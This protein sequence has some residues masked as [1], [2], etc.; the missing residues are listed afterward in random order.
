MPYKISTFAILSIA[1][2]LLKFI[3]AESA[4]CRE[5]R[6]NLLIHE[7]SPYLLKHAQNPVNWHPWGETAFALAEKEDK[8]VFLSIG[9][10][11][12]HWCNVME[13]ESFSDP[14]VAA[15]INEVFI[16]I[17]VDREERP[18]I[19][20]IYMKACQLLSPSC[21]WPLTLFLSSEGKPFYAATYIPKEN[22]F[23]R[24][25]LLELI[26]R[27]RELW[28]QERAALL[29]SAESL[30][31]AVI[32]MTLHLPGK[33]MDSSLLDKAF[34]DLSQDFDHR[35]GGFGKGAK[36]PK[37][38]SL[39]FLLRYWHRTGNGTALDM[40]EKTLTALY[41][42]GIYDQL[43]HG[44]HRYTTDRKWRIP[45]FEKM[46]YDQ[47]LLAMVYL[48][49]YQATGKEKYARIARKVLTYV[50]AHL[51]SKNGGFYSAESGDSEGEEGRFYLWPSAEIKNILSSDEW[52]AVSRIFSIREDGNYLDPVTAAKTGKN[53]LFAEQDTVDI[54]GFET[55]RKKLLAARNLRQRPE[56]DDKILTDWNGLMIAALAKGAQ[57][58]DQPHFGAAAKRAANFI[59]KNLRSR[60][61]KLLH[62]W[63][64]EKAGLT[65]NAAD[66]AFFTWGLLELYSWDFDTD[67]LQQSLALTDIL[68]KYYWDD[69]LGGFY[70]TEEN[71]RSILPRIKEIT[72]T[73]IPSSNAV[74]MTNL[75]KLSRLTGNSSFEAR[76]E[77]ISEL[78]SSSVRNSPRTFPMLLIG[79]DLA[80]APSQEVV[81]VGPRDSEDTHEMLEVL[82]RNYFPNT[83]VLL[84]PQDSRGSQIEEYAEFVEFMSAINNEATAYVCTNFRCN[85]P[86]TVPAVMLKSLNNLKTSK[87]PQ[88]NNG[89]K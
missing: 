5:S 62:R 60:N 49:A 46:L 32:S 47:A 37:P 41:Q 79:L 39:L 18:D 25:G 4:D 87:D 51:T 61:G 66:Y 42:G 30:N 80:L 28:N 27:V 10:L 15:L 35:Y 33:T 53:I 57:V 76:A 86:T 19:D 43:G 9:Y 52:A 13:E 64:D 71:K 85:F 26:P 81:I 82:R 54:A 22:R 75:L 14:G 67:W 36:F 31:A 68:V 78:V 48:E 74:S 20:Q 84:K 29:R 2:I 17:K 70:L 73:A 11:T 16:P 89:S 72:D 40:V 34:Q 88:K 59:L 23:G 21:G 3:M 50:L 58:L 8:P 12:C 38:L 69:K 7:S 1:L 77:K 44:F 63:R 45:H 56:L 55:I 6:N 65:A 24:I 83:A